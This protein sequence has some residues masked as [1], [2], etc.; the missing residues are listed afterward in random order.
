MAKMTREE[1]FQIIQEIRK[2]DAE[3]KH[4]EAYELRYKLPLAPHLAKALKDTVGAEELRSSKFDLS[5]ANEA[6]G[7]N[8]LTV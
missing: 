4:D 2:L 1:K 7:Q 5:E 8:W 6:Y 3:G